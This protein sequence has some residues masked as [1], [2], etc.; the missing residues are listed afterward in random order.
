MMLTGGGLRVALATTHLALSDVPG[1]ITRDSL[2]RTLRV[3]EHDLRERFGIEQYRYLNALRTRW[4]AEDLMLM[5]ERL[6]NFA[7]D[8]YWPG[9]RPT[10]SNARGT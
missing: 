8:R 1:A 3:V 4:I 10:A 2:E 6:F 9:R 5:R 7:L